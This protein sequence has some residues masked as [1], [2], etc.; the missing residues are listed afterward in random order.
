MRIYVLLLAIMFWFV[1]GFSESETKEFSLGWIA[2]IWFRW[3]ITISVVAGGLHLY[4]YTFRKQGDTERY[5]LKDLAQ[6]SAKFHFRNQVWDNMFWVLTGTVGFLTFYEAIM[7]WAYATG[8]A[9]QITFADNPYLFVALILITP[10]WTAFHFYWQHRAFHIPWVYRLGHD[11]HHKNVTVGPWSGAAVH[12]VEN[13]VWFSAVLI[14]LVIPS[15]PIHALFLMHLQVITAIT[16]H[17]G[18]DSLRVGRQKFKLGDFFHQ[19]HHRYYDCN[20]GTASG[21]WDKWFGTYHD[22]T[23][24]GDRRIAMH[25][26]TIKGRQ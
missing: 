18:Y 26:Q 12:P 6:N 22:G 17:V 1:L 23:E 13:L 16:T 9:P 5:E 3:L 15:H 24:D 2:Q 4:F 21:P 10:G 25:R 14:L 20:Y 11:W 7:M 8:L 19:L